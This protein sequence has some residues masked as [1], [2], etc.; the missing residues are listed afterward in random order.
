MSSTEG[1]MHASGVGV[2]E[3]RVVT[4]LIVEFLE[5]VDSEEIDESPY[6][7]VVRA[8]NWTPVVAVFFVVEDELPWLVMGAYWASGAGEIRWNYAWDANS[9]SGS[10]DLDAHMTYGGLPVS[11]DRIGVQPISGIV[12]DTW[13]DAITVTKDYSNMVATGIG[14]GSGYAAMFDTKELGFSTGLGVGTGT[15]SMFDERN[16][17]AIGIGVGTGEVF[18]QFD[19]QRG[20]GVA[21]GAPPSVRSD[22]AV[23]SVRGEEPSTVDANAELTEV[24]VDDG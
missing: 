10:I 23:P 20:I 12:M 22:T 24:E 9:Y 13:S 14:V 6:N 19:Y 8:S 21:V 11:L 7:V 3:G 17:Y 2:G 5:P 16:M 1:D 18:V 4:S 15:A